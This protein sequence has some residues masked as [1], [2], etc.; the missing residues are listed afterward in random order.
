MHAIW[1][2]VHKNAQES[3]DGRYGVLCLG[4]LSLA[5]AA[6]WIEP[7][8]ILCLL[9]VEGLPKRSTGGMTCCALPA[10]SL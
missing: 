5:D 10:M 2:Q 3:C 1:L 6:P 7:L 9:V 4:Q 8:S